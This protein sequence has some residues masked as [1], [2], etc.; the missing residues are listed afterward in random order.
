M[1]DMM[2]TPPPPSPR[3]FFVSTQA[4]LGPLPNVKEI[5][6]SANS[7]APEAQN[8]PRVCRV[9]VVDDGSSMEDRMAM[10]SAFPRFT[11]VF[12]GAGDTKGGEIKGYNSRCVLRYSG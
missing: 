11:Y 1:H 5:N 12:K 10:M 2:S 8:M 9:L 4:L 7:K 3:P 6:D